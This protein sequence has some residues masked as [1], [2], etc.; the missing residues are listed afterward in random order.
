M[1]TLKEIKDKVSGSES[2]LISLDGMDLREDK[3]G[4]IV[5]FANLVIILKN[6]GQFKDMVRFDRWT[7]Q[8]EIQE[9]GVYVPF[10]DKHVNEIW[11]TIQ[12]RTR[13]F[14][15]VPKDLVLNAIERVAHENSF[16]QAQYYIDNLE[17]WDKVE[18]L[19]TFISDV[20]G[21]PDDEYHHCVGMNFWKGM[22]ARIMRPGTKFDTVLVIE[23]AQ[24]IMKSTS[25]DAIAGKTVQG[26]EYPNYLGHIET[27]AHDLDSKDHLQSTSG[28]LL[29]EFAEGVALKRAKEMES[30]KTYITKTDD[31]YRAPYD[32]FPEKHP[33][34][35]VLVMTT[36]ETEYL[37]DDTGNRRFVSIEAIGSTKI[38]NQFGD[39]TLVCDIPYILD[40]RDQLFAEAKYRV[41]VGETFYEYPRTAMEAIHHEKIVRSPYYARIAKW[42]NDPMQM[43]MEKGVYEYTKMDISQ[44]FEGMDVWVNALGGV[45]AQ[46]DMG[47]KMMIGK[48]LTHLGYER[49]RVRRDG[50]RQYRYF[51]VG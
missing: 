37:K 4:V 1:K 45:V 5:N 44:G 28:Q 41:E 34:R 2:N 49:R 38:I 14:Q 19:P 7:R 27:S 10:I 48:D 42:L 13:A 15:K 6:A 21:C 35:F 33:R 43:N 25:L 20:Y 50:V 26:I 39:E 8:M 11:E 17:P 3:N 29:V 40:N 51:K 36:N 16:D 30:L 9:N 22:V 46:L 18:R 47:K 31:V 23:G 24:S 32:K 12:L